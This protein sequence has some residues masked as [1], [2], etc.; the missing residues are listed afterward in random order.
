MPSE[1][2]WSTLVLC[3]AYLV[4][5]VAPATSSKEALQAALDI[6]A[7]GMRSHDPSTLIFSDY[8]TVK[9][10]LCDSFFF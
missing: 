1:G 7:E 9:V 8:F 5:V 10:V 3:A 6:P 2:V 4:L